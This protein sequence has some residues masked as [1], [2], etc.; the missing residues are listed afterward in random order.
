MKTGAENEIEGKVHEVK[1]KIKEKWDGSRTTR[2]S[3]AKASAK[4]W[5]G[6]FRRK[7]GRCKRSSRSRD[8]AGASRMSVEF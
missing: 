5:A 7:S 4:K 1:G 8:G 3:K 6:R 2:A